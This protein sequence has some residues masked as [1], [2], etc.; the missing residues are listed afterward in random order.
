MQDDTLQEVT[1]KLRERIFDL[2]EPLV[3]LFNEV[4]DLKALPIAADNEYTER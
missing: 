4:E 1:E 3:V 2:L